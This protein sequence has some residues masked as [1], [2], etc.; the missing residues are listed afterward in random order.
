MRSGRVPGRPWVLL[1]SAALF[2]CL[3]GWLLTPP[4]PGP[5]PAPVTAEPQTSGPDSPGRTSGPGA[6]SPQAAAT[7]ARSAGPG[8]ATSPPIPKTAT[9]VSRVDAAVQSH[10][11]R[12]WPADL[13]K[14]TALRLVRDGEAVLGA[15]ATGEGRDRWPTVFGTAPPGAGDFS[16]LRIQAAIA[17]RDG[18]SRQAVVHLVWAGADP[19]GSYAEMRV[20]DIYFTLT[21]TKGHSVWTPQP[22]R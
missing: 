6:A 9:A 22:L 8:T 3:A 14:A 5:V 20:T 10:L 2:V 4:P 13:P 16:R 11:E 1:C 17:R 18:S 7:S 12:S 19:G 15:D 21:S